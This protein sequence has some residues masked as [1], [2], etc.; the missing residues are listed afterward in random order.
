MARRSS[1]CPLSCPP[2][3]HRRHDDDVSRSSSKLVLGLSDAFRNPNGCRLPVTWCACADVCTS[4]LQMAVCCQIC[5]APPGLQYSCAPLMPAPAQLCSLPS[6]PA[7]TAAP[8]PLPRALLPTPLPLP[9]PSAL[10]TA[11][12][13]HPPPPAAGL[14]APR[15]APSPAMRPTGCFRRATSWR[16]TP[17][18]TRTCASSARP[19]CACVPLCAVCHSCCSTLSQN[20]LAC[21]VC[22]TTRI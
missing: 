17:R 3:L 1:S 13:P 22:I 5:D 16:C 21:I 15:A 6:P 2:C 11:P 18:T 14:R 12:L 7:P 8:L 10:L 4:K 20:Y 9:L 19:R